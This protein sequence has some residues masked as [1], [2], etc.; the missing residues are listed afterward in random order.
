[1]KLE[2]EIIPWGKVKQTQEKIQINEPKEA[3]CKIKAELLGLN[4]EGI[5]PPTFPLLETVWT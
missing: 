5:I 1:M 2:L 4:E 3:D